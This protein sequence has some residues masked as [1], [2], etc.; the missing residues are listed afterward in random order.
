LTAH[1]TPLPAKKSPAELAALY[2][3]RQ[4]WLERAER[5]LRA[6]QFV[7]EAPAFPE[8]GALMKRLQAIL[9]V[10]ADAEC[11]AEE[12]HVKL[13]ERCR[14]IGRTAYLR[15]F[16]H[17]L[18]TG[19]KVIRGES[20][21]SLD[22]LIGTGERILTKLQK[23]QLDEDS[24]TRLEGKL[25]LLLQTDRAGDSAEAKRDEAIDGRPY[26]SDQRLFMR[27]TEPSLIVQIGKTRHRSVDWSL[28]GLLLAGVERSPADVGA[29]VLLHFG[30][31]GGKVHEDRATIVKH[32]TDDKLLALQLRRFGSQMVNLKQEIE[33]RG[34]LPK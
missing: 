9:D 28:G 18:E 23:L 10:A 3:A 26:Q 27:Y 24:C 15:F 21:F 31:P 16:E 22:S 4:E 19:R 34:L 6:A 29:P 25:E 8:P 13:A 2:A 14:A 7:A 32:K 11:L 17:V 12:D 30:V 20:D 33:A 1:A 5:D